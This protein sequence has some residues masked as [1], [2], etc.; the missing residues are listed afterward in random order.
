MDSSHTLKQRVKLRLGV[1]IQPVEEF[2]AISL[3]DKLGKQPQ[4][5]SAHHE[6]N[7]CEFF[8]RYLPC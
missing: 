2:L 5:P 8:L 3:Q 6:A 1:A 7:Q 4:F